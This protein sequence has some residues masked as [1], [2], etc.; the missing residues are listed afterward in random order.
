MS[1]DYGAGCESYKFYGSVQIEMHMS[2]DM[3]WKKTSMVLDQ[4]CSIK[5]TMINQL[6]SLS[7]ETKILHHSQQQES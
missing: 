3:N 6:T 2:L 7:E 5:A 1:L 4:H